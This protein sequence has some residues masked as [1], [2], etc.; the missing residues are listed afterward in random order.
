MKLTIIIV[1]YNTKELTIDCLESIYKFP[2]RERFEV[3][4]VDNGSKENFQLPTPSFKN[5]KFIKNTKNVGFARANNQGIK[6]AKGE[7]ILLLNS[8]TTVTKNSLNELVKFAETHPDA[9]VVAPRLLNKDGSIQNS[10]FNLPTIFRSLKQYIFKKGNVLDKY[11]PKSE[12]P[13]AVESVVGAAFIITPKARKKA[14]FLD[15]RYFMYYEDL[16]YCR[17]VGNL[18]LKVYYLPKVKIYHHHGASGKGNPL[19][20]ARLISSSKIYHGVLG[21][22]LLTTIIK[23]G[24]KLHSIK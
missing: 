3:I 23:F 24:M 13:I 21:Y 9:G 17:K 12:S 2:P 11:V 15:E 18:G 8:D 6:I 20:N 4:V 19:Q 7:Y 10:V 1:N 16:D 14:G 5:L 22:Y